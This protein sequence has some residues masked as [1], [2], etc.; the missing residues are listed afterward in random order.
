MKF[1]RNKHVNNVERWLNS[2]P[3]I[4]LHP[5]PL[6]RHPYSFQYIPNQYSQL[7]DS[8][9]TPFNLAASPFYQSNDYYTMSTT[10]S[11]LHL[12][13]SVA[14]QESKLLL[15]HSYFSCLSLTLFFKM[16]ILL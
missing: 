4:L 14:Q 1:K 3:S 13:D 2:R 9:E 7:S 16:K 11:N 12:N 10:L 6:V 15:P 8:I 5:R